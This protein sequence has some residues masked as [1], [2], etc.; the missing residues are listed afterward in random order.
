MAPAAGRAFQGFALLRPL[1]RS[2]Q[3]H[4]GCPFQS[5][6]RAIR[7]LKSYVHQNEPLTKLPDTIKY[8][9]SLQ[10]LFVAC[11]G[12]T[13]IYPEYQA[14]HANVKLAVVGVAFCG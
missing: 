12:D 2:C 6:V 7:Q 8:P 14:L 10:V 5:L 9:E 1:P 4:R 11:V 13:I 3:P